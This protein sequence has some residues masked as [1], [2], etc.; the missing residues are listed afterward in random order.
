[1]SILERIRSGSDSTGMQ[2]VLGLVL[3]SFVG[4]GFGVQ[5]D[6]TATVA[7][8]NGERINGIEFA[9][10]Y[11]LAERRMQ[12]GRTE[13]M[14]QDEREAL[15]E[16]V[17]QQLVRQKALVQEAR[18]VGLEVS[19]AEVA[20]AL[21]DISFLVN[22]EGVFDRRAYEQ[23]LRRQG[24]TR[25][26]FEGEL[27]DQL[28]VGKLQE[29][30]ILGA[31]VSKPLIEREWIADN[32]KIDLSYVR[33][34]PTAFHTS[35]E[36][37]DAD[38]DAWIAEHEAEIQARYDRDLPRLY[39]QAERVGVT[40][41][42]LTGGEQDMPLADLKAEAEQLKA[43]IE[44]GADMGQLA[45]ERS[46]DPSAANEG[47]LADYLDVA[48]LDVRVATA[49]QDLAPGQLSAPVVGDRDVRLYRLD[50]RIEART[51]P[52]EEVQRDI[53]LQL[54]REQ[55]GP[56]AAAAFANETL[57]PAW[58]E[59]GA[60]PSELVSEAGLRVDQTGLI[61]ASG[62]GGGLFRPPDGMM[63]AARAAAEGD[64]LP[65]VYE[66]A[67]VLWVGQV[68]DREDPDPTALEDEADSIRQQ[69]LIKRRVAFFQAWVDDVVARAEVTY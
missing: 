5:G 34:R 17:L 46:D 59:A 25:G 4:W 9:R 64:V 18:A 24:K 29:L 62:E 30:A 55:E 69:G 42:R 54:Y 27:R 22:D 49:L 58:K 11:D 66:S 44:A 60:V 43:D 41:I 63:G 52:L 38:L 15:R 8:V 37:S 61:P 20:D 6:R 10:A 3:V 19:D 53:A 50:E 16:Q 1:M 32:T 68:T 14:S 67:G 35:I 28:L 57:L 33:I 23:F 40:M 26:D 56:A 7:T 48:S 13:P 2:I 45:L 36:P 31:S 39:D 47:K 21:L 51:T 65:E 12:E